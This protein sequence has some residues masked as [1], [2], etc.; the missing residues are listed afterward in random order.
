VITKIHYHGTMPSEISTHLK[1]VL[2]VEDND[3]VREITC[4][5]LAE[6]ALEV[7]PVASGEAGLDAFQSGDFDIVVT[8]VS[9]PAMSGV[10]F[11]RQIKKLS[12][13]VPVILASGYPLVLQDGHLGSNV[14]SITKPFDPMQLNALIRELCSS[15]A[16]AGL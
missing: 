11:A 2:Y 7:V 5:L 6:Y 3:L 13:S 10:D 1:R 4:D 8:D 9:L 14:R 12:P 15:A 16:S